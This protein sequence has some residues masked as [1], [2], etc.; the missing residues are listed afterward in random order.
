M[1]AR[2]KR[3]LPAKA[4]IFV[5]IRLDAEEP[6]DG[7]FAVATVTSSVDTN[8]GELTPFTPAFNG[9]FADAEKFGDFGNSEQIGQIIDRNSINFFIGYGLSHRFTLRLGLISH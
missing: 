9:Q 3:Y 6:E 7:F 4:N 1:I 8:G 2:L 5:L